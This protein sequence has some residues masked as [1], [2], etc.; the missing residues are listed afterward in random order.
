M[1][2]DSTDLEILVAKI[3]KQLAP[4]S[5]VLHDVK[6]DG[7]D[8]QTKR[9]I[10]VLVRQQVGQYKIQIVID[11]KDHK[12]PI[13]VKGVGEFYTLMTDV[14]AQKGVLVCPTGFSAAA[15]TLAK[16]KQIDLYSPVD[17]DPHKWRVK[18]TVPALCDYRTAAIGF[19]VR[20]SSPY[21][22]MMPEG[23]FFE[24][25]FFDLEGNELGT[26]FAGATG[27]WNDG[28]FPKE[29]GD[30]ENLPVFDSLEVKTDN[31]YGTIVPVE[32]SVS[33][34]VDRDLY[35]GQFPIAQIS[36]FKDEVSGGVMTNAFSVH[37]LSPE[38]VEK[39]WQRIGTE[40]DAPIRPVILRRCPYLC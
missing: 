1:T 31:G 13:D 40:S 22:F 36:G 28:R 38:E 29:L 18:V 8:S 39:N 32:L 6:L 10:D 26:A 27:K 19:G 5:E 37:I 23:F 9:Q 34:R 21:P 30:H 7:F 2:K 17:T 24:S 16:T 20:M 14:R 4:D 25:I 15:K 35:F 11:C 33:L 3:Q 12:K